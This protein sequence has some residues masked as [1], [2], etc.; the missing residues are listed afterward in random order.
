[1][2]AAEREFQE[3]GD[4]EVEA[5]HWNLHDAKGVFRRLESS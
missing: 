3:A 5:Q 2:I 1:M 4:E